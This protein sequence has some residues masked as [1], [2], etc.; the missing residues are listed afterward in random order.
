MSS[1][2]SLR[3][4]AEATGVSTAS[5]SMILNGISLERL[6]SQRVASGLAEAERIGYRTP[7]ARCSGK[8]IAVLSPSVATPNHPK[9]LAGIAAA[10]PAAG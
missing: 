10:G 2:P 9:M 4:F 7:S 3:D 1:K 5:V 6:S 8:Q